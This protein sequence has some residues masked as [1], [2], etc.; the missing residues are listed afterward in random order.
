[1]SGTAS[2]KIPAVST[3]PPSG[4]VVGAWHRWVSHQD[5]TLAVT[6]FSPQAVTLFLAVVVG[7]VAALAW[8]PALAPL[9]AVNPRVAVAGPPIILGWYLV[10]RALGVPHGLPFPRFL[11][12]ALVGNSL[13]LGYMALLAATSS[14]TGSV[15]H[16]AA[17]VTGAAVQG[18]LY[19]VTL[20]EPF[21]AVA[22]AAV[23]LLCG[24]AAG[25]AQRGVLLVDAVVAVGTMLYTG[26]MAVEHQR[27]VVFRGA[28]TDALHA[29]LL[30]ERSTQLEELRE[31][32][33]AELGRGH[34]VRG[35]LSV[36]DINLGLL[37]EV[38]AGRDTMTATE[39][40]QLLAD[41]TQAL[42]RMK[43]LVTE[44]RSA[45]RQH[46]E[47]RSPVVE[48]GGAVERTLAGLRRVQPRVD[49]VTDV[50]KG[51][52][53]H[54]TGGVQTVE[55]IFHNLA[56]NASQGDGRRGAGRVVVRAFVDEATGAVHLEV[57]DDGPG[58]TAL[59]LSAPVQAFETTKDTGT[60]LGLYTCERLAWSCSG[61]LLRRNAPDGGAVVT[62]VLPRA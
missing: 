53:A 8:V 62:V 4:G 58:F 22:L 48:L 57:Q 27:A 41:V 11:A 10:M 52:H 51:I 2:S 39:Q 13:S 36:L 1:V 30:N 28:A 25:D 17:L 59:Q 35:Q 16:G 19:R 60:G 44:N 32:L 46:L 34:D 21:A 33:A 54:A 49:F 31:Q 38:V 42:G 12:L 14:V 56:L 18:Y 61:Q 3:A 15:L 47:A 29:Q 45:A 24:A 55:R 37:G 6:A 26:R 50:A 9:I 43:Q 20:T 7:A 5:P 23:M 40:E